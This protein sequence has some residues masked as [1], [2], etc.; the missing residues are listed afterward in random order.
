MKADVPIQN[1]QQVD[2]NYEAHRESTTQAHMGSSTEQTVITETKRTTEATIR[3]EHKQNFLDLPVTFSQRT[4]T[5]TIPLVSEGTMVDSDINLDKKLSAEQSV[6][7]SGSGIN[8]EPEV[9]LD[10]HPI[11][12]HAFEFFENT[13]KNLPPVTDEKYTRYEDAVKSKNIQ[14]TDVTNNAFQSKLNEDLQGLNILPEPAPEMGFMPKPEA[15]PTEKI[16]DKVKKLEYIHGQTAQTP[17]SGSIRILPSQSPAKVFPQ[18]PQFVKSEEKVEQ[19]NFMRTETF[20]PRKSPINESFLRTEPVVNRAASPKPSNEGIAME[21][22][23]TCKSPVPMTGTT[24]QQQFSHEKTSSFV[25]YSA[26]TQKIYPVQD[27]FVPIQPTFQP[28]FQPVPIQERPVQTV[29]IQPP[30]K[31]MPDQAP[32]Q[33]APAS[34][35]PIQP[36]P[37]PA[38]PIQPAPVHIAPVFS[39]PMQPSFIHTTSYQTASSQVEDTEQFI[40]PKES[41][42]LFEEKIKQEEREKYLYDLKAPTL[43]KEVFKPQPLPKPDPL[44]NVVKDLGIEPG[45]PPEILFAPKPVLERK[46]SY[47]E[48]IEKTLEMNMEREPDKVPPGGVRILPQRTTPQRLK[49]ESPY[50]IMP[51]PVQR[52][53]QPQPLKTE[54]FTEDVVDTRFESHLETTMQQESSYSVMYSQP[55]TFEP[56]PI[57]KPEYFS[58]PQEPV[59]QYTPVSYTNVPVSITPTFKEPS[60]EAK[61]LAGYRHVEPPK[62]SSRPKSVE[63]VPLG[64]TQFERPK[65]SILGH[66]TA[67]P[68]AKPEPIP[69]VAESVPKPQPPA[70][71][72]TEY[73]KPVPSVAPAVKP[74]QK[75]EFMNNNE[76]GTFNSYKNFVKSEQSTIT[77][78]PYF[79]QNDIQPTDV[80]KAKSVEKPDT[81]VAPP[82]DSYDY[83]KVCFGLENM[84]LLFFFSV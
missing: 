24:T 28:S 58:P 20:A 56:Q 8:T 55:T 34:S 11:R 35:A 76:Q 79:R 65:E 22:L 19:Q 18:V 72:K 53:P 51:M 48:K 75:F 84:C 80:P 10:F 45:T 23:W 7:T 77:T 74:K 42:R 5:P 33:T 60:V 9:P 63:P 49:S 40:S 3:M 30:F 16:S 46:E 37:I 64:P 4:Q 67:V 81:V 62:F 70:F 15:F 71:K 73:K 66:S 25:T 21:K 39:M 38:P 29:P 44:Q 61:N 32:V 14:R 1:I 36:A 82:V 83:K 50:R 59:Q 43:V 41:K 57:Q 31:P 54:T 78:E 13:I 52:Q 6:Q 12:K 27:Q 47:V 17:L 2:N 69:K 68:V 26:Q